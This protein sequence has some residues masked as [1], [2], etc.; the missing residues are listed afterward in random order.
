[1]TAIVSRYTRDETVFG[2]G[3]K[4]TLDMKVSPIRTGPT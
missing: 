1:M 2:P 4:V 3:V